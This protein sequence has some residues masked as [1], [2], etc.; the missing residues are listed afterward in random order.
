M[1]MGRSA[2]FLIKHMIASQIDVVNL[3]VMSHFSGG[4]A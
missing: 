3:S 1:G 2:G 4:I